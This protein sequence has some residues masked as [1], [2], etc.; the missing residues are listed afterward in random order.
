MSRVNMLVV[1]FD[2]VKGYGFADCDGKEVFL[3]YSSIIG[4]GLKTLSQGQKIKAELVEGP[5]GYSGLNI[6]KE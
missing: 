1:W 3:H 2:T 4:D 5:K 6:T